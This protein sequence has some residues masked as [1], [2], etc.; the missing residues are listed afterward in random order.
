M[1]PV[2]VD[3]GQSRELIMRAIIR[4][5]L[6][7]IVCASLL[8]SVGMIDTTNIV[9]IKDMLD[10]AV[11]VGSKDIVCNLPYQPD[12]YLWFDHHSSEAKRTPP[13]PTDFRGAYNLAPS[14]A[15][16]VYHYFL[17]FH[18]KLERFANLVRDT[19][20]LDSADL[21]IEEVKNP[22]GNFLLG[23]LLDS[24]THLDRVK[25][26]AQ[27]YLE[28]KY[29]IIDLLLEYSTDE[30]L[31]MPTTQRWIDLYREEEKAAIELIEEN[32]TLDGNIVFSD[33]RG[34]TLKPINRF[35]IY[36]LPQFVDG[37]I[38]VAISD[39]EVGVY[40]EIAVGHSI[41]NRTSTVN[42][43]DICS[44]YG[45]GGHRTVGVC[46]PSIEETSQVLE[47]ILASC[48]EQESIE[49]Q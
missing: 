1:I 17:P 43:G 47:E 12:A 16:V 6:D 3:Q 34:K 20:I 44:W 8:K 14:T 19:D 9:H 26:S 40:N 35:I 46:R 10:G 42:V 28:W 23:F 49:R 29:T 27:D 11:D 4:G 13:I 38:T 36:T 24:R 37:N 21:T 7:G 39:G 2:E 33:F 31:E 5:D 15:S 25:D 45:G 22:Q 41:F 18:P 48:R 30:I 32:T